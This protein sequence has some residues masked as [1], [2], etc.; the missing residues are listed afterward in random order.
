MTAN[1]RVKSLPK[2][3]CST[4][5]YYFANRRK[6]PIPPKSKETIF[7]YDP[8]NDDDD[9]Y[10]DIQLQLFEAQL[11]ATQSKRSKKHDCE[12]ESSYGPY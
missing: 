1:L 10:H 7:D 6:G 11:L 5:R 4:W 8:A 9:G 2:K 3:L 12:T